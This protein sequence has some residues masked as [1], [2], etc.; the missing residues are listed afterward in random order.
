MQGNACEIFWVFVHHRLINN[1]S[2]ETAGEVVLPVLIG[3]IIN[4]PQVSASST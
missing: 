4:I 3:P 1:D 2:L